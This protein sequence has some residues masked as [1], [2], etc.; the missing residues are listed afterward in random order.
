MT[1]WNF[2]WYFIFCHNVR[3]RW[4]IIVRLTKTSDF[5]NMSSKYAVFLR[6]NCLHV[7]HI[8]VVV[9]VVIYVHEDKTWLAK[10]FMEVLDLP[11]LEFKFL[12]LKEMIFGLTVI[13]V[14]HCE[15]VLKV[16]FFVERSFAFN[17]N[18]IS[19]FQM[20]QGFPSGL[21]YHN[22]SGKECVF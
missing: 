16:F 15:I 7:W 12:I 19:L 2:W 4:L 18:W 8:W 10:T 20:F 6:P 17:T 5:K 22:E 13:V 1:C 3:K 9:V 21:V 14:I 11:A